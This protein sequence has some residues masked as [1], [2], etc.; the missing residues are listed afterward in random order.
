VAPEGPEPSSDR[1]GD[2]NSPESEV[3][4]SS[5][6]SKVGAPTDVQAAD[7]A[8]KSGSVNLD[9]VAPADRLTAQEYDRLPEV[10]NSLE[11][12]RILAVNRQQVS[13][14][15]AEGKLPGAQIGRTWRFSKSTIERIVAGGWK[16]DE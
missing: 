6:V 15:A 2:K 13:R 3:L 14:W 5:D 4:P 1:P 7:V 8:P 9:A 16:P 10:L 11:V 12:A